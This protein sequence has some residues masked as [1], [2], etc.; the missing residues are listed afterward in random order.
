MIFDTNILTVWHFVLLLGMFIG[1]YALLFMVIRKRPVAWR[2]FATGR[3]IYYAGWLLALLVMIPAALLLYGTPLLWGLVGS[4]LMI[5]LIGRLD[6]DRSISVRRQLL[7]QAAIAGWAVYFGWAIPHISNPFGEGVIILSIGGIL[8]F[9]WLLICMNAMNFLD[10]ADGLASLVGMIAFGALAGISL[11]PATQDTVTLAFSFIALGA[12]LA[13]FLW[14]APPARVYLGTSGSWFLG[15]FLGMTAIIGGGKIATAFIVLALPVLDALFVI[16]YRMIKRRNPTKG[17]TTS[18][19]HHR[20]LAAHIHPWG[21]LLIV[22]GITSLLG[23]VAVVTP[24]NMKIVTL[25]VFACIFFL[26]RAF[27]MRTAQ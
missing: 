1:M 3:P 21:I 14:N 16:L 2:V 6:E 20:L 24:T 26:S 25:I 9:V 15:L 22:G 7:W 13:F 17:D 27:T 4:V 8:A 18:H 11:L 19:I 10:G 12:L 23:V 5:V